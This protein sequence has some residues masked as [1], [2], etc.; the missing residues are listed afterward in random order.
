VLVDNGCADFSADLAGAARP[1]ARYVRTD[2]NLGFTG[3]PAAARRRAPPA[4]LG[5]VLNS[6][7]LEPAAR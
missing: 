1:G 7:R 3:G 4:R 2:A 5:V 6:D